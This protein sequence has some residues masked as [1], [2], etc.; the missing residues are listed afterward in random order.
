MAKLDLHI[1]WD[2]AAQ[3]ATITTQSFGNPD[4][5]ECYVV[6][7]DWACI[8]AVVRLVLR[9]HLFLGDEDLP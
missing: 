7:R 2:G 5:T 6:P 3:T 9:E 4:Y 1:S 8:K